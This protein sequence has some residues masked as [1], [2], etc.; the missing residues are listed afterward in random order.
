MKHYKYVYLLKSEYDG[1]V[2]AVI[3][4]NKITEVIEAAI[5]EAIDEYYAEEFDCGQTSYILNYLDD[6]FDGEIDYHTNIEEIYY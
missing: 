1:T 2:D 4:T 3:F 6:K 5:Q